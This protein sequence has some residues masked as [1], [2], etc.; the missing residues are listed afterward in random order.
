MILGALANE[1]FPSKGQFVDIGTGTGA[2][3]MMLTQK[4]PQR[5]FLGIEIDKVSSLEACF[6]FSQAPFKEQLSVLNIDF[7][8]WETNQLF[9]GIISNPPYYINSLEGT[10][11]RANRAKHA[12]YFS[13]NDFLSK[14]YRLT[15]EDGV[16]MYIIPSDDVDFH[17]HSAKDYGWCLV[18]RIDIYSK[19][20]NLVR[21]VLV[22]RKKVL[23]FSKKDLVIRNVDN[24][25][26]KEYISLTVEYHHKQL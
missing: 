8:Q 21:C 4:C 9:D 17:V 11:A 6:N 18:Q 25:Y 16:L 26:T 7:F 12:A 13:F 1:I 5:I 10:N 22:F 24:S 2:I 14:C 19:V 23:V 3:A 20:D 15:N